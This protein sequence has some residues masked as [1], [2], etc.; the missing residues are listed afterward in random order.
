[1]RENKIQNYGI[2]LH[3]WAAGFDGAALRK[4]QFSG[5]VQRVGGW[6]DA[7]RRSADR[8]RHLAVL[9]RQGFSREIAHRV[10]DAK[11]VLEVR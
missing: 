8:D 11:D 3:F 6:S 7:E 4:S 2:L 9:A 1:M 5:F 10:I